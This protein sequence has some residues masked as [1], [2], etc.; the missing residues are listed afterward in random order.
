[1]E[2]GELACPGI[3][4]GY[5]PRSVWFKYIVPAA[6]V[7]SLSTT[8]DNAHSFGVRV[9]MD[10]G[11]LPRLELLKSTSVAVSAG[12]LLAIQVCDAAAFEPID[13]TWAIGGACQQVLWTV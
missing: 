7:L 8:S 12:A 2:A 4:D 1:V 6:G 9:F 3:T 13:V 5:T 10:R 11:S